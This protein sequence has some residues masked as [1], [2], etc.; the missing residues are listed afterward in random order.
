MPGVC[1]NKSKG[2]CSMERTMLK[3]EGIPAILWGAPQP[4][5]LVA[6]H[7]NLSHKADTVIEL[8]A[9]V[10]CSRGYQVLSFDL[11]GHGA[12][13]IEPTPC[14]MPPCMDSL[15]A[16]MRYAH[17]HWPAIG[18]FACSMGAYISLVALEQERL[19][20]CLFLSP[21]VDMQS[22]IGGMMEAC[23]V[24]PQQLEQQKRISTPY[25]PELVW[26][27]YNFVAAHP[28]SCWP[29]PT[30]IL[31][32]QMDDVCRY[33]ILA[34][35][36]KRFGCEVKVLPGSEHY[37]HTPHQLAAYQTWLQAHIPHR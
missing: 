36:A 28:I 26:S 29:S 18:L 13:K 4:H 9:E 24:T 15:K 20:P 32:G 1:L 33:D 14:H 6:V 22:V 11:P 19:S 16:I 35:F 34:G 17:A 27:E 8:L 31:Y 37:F 7:G 2:E 21:V 5:V 12:R 25:G 23:G 3:I 30:A 10:A